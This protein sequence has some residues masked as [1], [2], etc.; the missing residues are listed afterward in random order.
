MEVKK[1]VGETH[2]NLQKN[3]VP[4]TLRGPSTNTYGDEIT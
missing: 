3:Y 2:I 1:K 4:W